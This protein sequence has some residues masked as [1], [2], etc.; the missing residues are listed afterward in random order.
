MMMLRTFLA[1]LLLLGDPLVRVSQSWGVGDLEIPNLFF[2]NDSCAVGDDC[3][4]KGGEEKVRGVPSRPDS[5]APPRGWPISFD[6]LIRMSLRF[7]ANAASTSLHYCGTL[8]A[9]IG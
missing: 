3:E 8:C 6:W 2:R 4:R 7:I 5:E 9:S 1:S